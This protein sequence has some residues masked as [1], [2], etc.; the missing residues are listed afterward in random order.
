MLGLY[1]EVTMICQYAQIPAHG[2]TFHRQLHPLQSERNGI[3]EPS[4][5]WQ[6][7]MH[8]PIQTALIGFGVA[9]K[10]MHAPFLKTLDTRYTVSTVLERHK[11]DSA[12]LFPEATIA[13]SMD[14][15]LRDDSIELVVITTPNDSHYPYARAA[16]QAGKHVVVDKPFTI[17]SADALALVE[18]A[19][20]NNRILSVYQNRRYVSDFRTAAMLVRSGKLGAIHEYEERYD[21]YR[22]EAR[23]GAWREQPEPGSG[24]LY[25]L[26]AHLFDHALYL[27]G[28][29]NTITAEVRLQRPHAHTVDYFDVTLGYRFLRVRLKAGMLVR[30][31]GP[32]FTIHGTDGS[33]IKYGD[34]PQ[35]AFLRAGQLPTEVPG[36]G[37][38]TA[39]MHG[40][41]HTLHQGNLV[42]ERLPSLKGNYGWYYEHLY[43]TIREGAPLRERPEHGYNGVRLVEL[44]MESSKR[45]AT[46]PCTGLVD[47]PYP[48]DEG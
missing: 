27:F 36:W 12:G 11:S 21:R 43:A 4:P 16:L 19:R 38:E 9:G 8:P 13:R 18:L 20:N 3:F 34:D 31:P 1:Y 29:P 2:L 7:N 46:I 44:A 25:D 5:S 33:F 37:I 40:H 30:E 6:T 32:R 26:G 35:E 45:Q 14:E 47:V 42:N 28:L 15:L 17:R 10:F 23:P 48:S 24:I 22:P 41:L 39:D